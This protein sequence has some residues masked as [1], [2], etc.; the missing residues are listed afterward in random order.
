M[1]FSFLWNF[2]CYPFFGNL[3]KEEFILLCQIFHLLSQ[4][5]IL[6]VN[7]DRWNLPKSFRFDGLRPPDQIGRPWPPLCEAFSPRILAQFRCRSSSPC[8][9]SFSHVLGGHIILNQV[10]AT[11]LLNLEVVSSTTLPIENLLEFTES[12]TVLSRSLVSLSQHQ[13]LLLLLHL[14]RE[15]KV[16]LV[17]Y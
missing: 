3:S 15:L 10:I 16:D 7:L 13:R 1:Y 8:N 14:N 9:N 11:C 17:D 5:L 6:L 4:M 2:F 12:S